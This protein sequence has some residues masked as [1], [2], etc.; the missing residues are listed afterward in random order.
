MN[1]KPETYT[2]KIDG[3]NSFAEEIDVLILHTWA[4]QP[5]WWPFDNYNSYP[6]KLS[7]FT[8]FR[9]PSP[10]EY[11]QIF[12]NRLLLNHYVHP[13][14]GQTFISLDGVWL[15][16]FNFLL[17]YFPISSLNCLHI[18]SKIRGRLVYDESER[19]WKEGVMAR[20]TYET[21][22]EWLKN[23]TPSLSQ[24]NR[25]PGR[26]SNWAYMVPVSTTSITLT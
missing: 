8:E 24:V 2:V 14:Y 25:H 18:P 3:Q 15:R 26:V 20:L 17:V 9:I 4:S 12:Y 23:V 16:P 5:S 1:I 6:H 13:I 22:S 11:L 19:I 21:C 7:Q 10:I